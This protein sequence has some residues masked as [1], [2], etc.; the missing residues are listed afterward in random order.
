MRSTAAESAASSRAPTGPGSFTSTCGSSGAARS[1]AGIAGGW[2]GSIT[3]ELI[4]MSA[5]D[6]EEVAGGDGEPGAQPMTAARPRRSQDEER[7]GGP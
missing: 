4:E 6:D 1:W 7:I 5:R 3:I 2:R